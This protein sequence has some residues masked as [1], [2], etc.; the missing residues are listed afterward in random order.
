MSFVRWT[1]RSVDGEI[2]GRVR[3][4][5]GRTGATLGEIVSLALRH[6]LA[7]AEAE[8]AASADPI[9]RAVEQ[10]GRQAALSER[11]LAGLRR[12][13]GASTGSPR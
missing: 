13:F 6:G 4:L 10:L 5:Q 7:A 8:L 12:Q 2:V 11:I 1:V 3:A 9:G